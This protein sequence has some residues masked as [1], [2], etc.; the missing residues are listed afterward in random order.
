MASRA[1]GPRRRRGARRV[2]PRGAPPRAGARTAGAR[3]RPPPRRATPR[4]GERRAP[5][6]RH[7]Y[8]RRA[9][10]RG[11]RRLQRARGAAQTLPELARKRG[12][13]LGGG[14]GGASRRRRDRRRRRR[15]RDG[16]EDAI[17]PPRARV[18]GRVARQGLRERLHRVLRNAVWLLPYGTSRGQ[19]EDVGERGE[20]GGERVAHLGLARQVKQDVR[21][22]EGVH[23]RRRRHRAR[24]RGDERRVRGSGVAG[25]L[26]RRRCGGHRDAEPR[27]GLR[28]ERRRDGCGAPAFRKRRRDAFNHRAQRIHRGRAVLPLAERLEQRGVQERVQALAARATA[29]QRLGGVQRAQKRQARGGVFFLL[30]PDP[31]GDVRAALGNCLRP[32]RARLRRRALGSL[33]PAAG[34][35]APRSSAHSACRRSDLRCDGAHETGFRSRAWSPPRGARRCLRRRPPRPPRRRRGRRSERARR[36]PRAQVPRAVDHRVRLRALVLALRPRRELARELLRRRRRVVARAGP[37][38]RRQLARRRRRAQ[39]RGRRRVARARDSPRV[40]VRVRIIIARRA[41]GSAGAFGPAPRFGIVVEA[42]VAP[43][44]ARRDLR[45]S[46]FAVVKRF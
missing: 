16:P 43:L 21:R 7:R 15:A 22:Q 33:A 35:S 9:F 39:A 2:P 17:G 10:V 38:P 29:A 5:Q 13:R 34:A 25:A 26:H 3:L 45:P 41:F 40:R 1:A 8:G 44:V 36:L 23:A 46:A 6:E 19:R 18:G 30:A 11:V 42:Y 27:A 4:A 28:G 32:R 14:G 12:R 20:T 31:P 37:A 24:H